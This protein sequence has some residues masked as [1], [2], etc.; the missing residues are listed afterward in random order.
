MDTSQ[1]V[2]KIE[3]CISDILDNGCFRDWQPERRRKAIYRLVSAR[4]NADL[5][6]HAY[7]RDMGIMKFEQGFREVECD[8]NDKYF[9]LLTSLSELKIEQSL[10]RILGQKLD[11]A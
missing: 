3:N 11:T 7:M 5:A 9:H 4:I 6:S 10:E 2:S 1:I 8:L